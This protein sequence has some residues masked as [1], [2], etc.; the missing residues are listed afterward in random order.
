MNKLNNDELAFD[1]V[2]KLIAD[3]AIT[4]EAKTL[5]MTMQPKTSL[6]A[7]RMLLNETEEML[8]VLKKGLHVPF[9]SSDSIK[10]LL[11]KVDKGLILDALELEK[12]ADFIR[13]NRLLKRFLSK[14]DNNP[15]LNSYANELTILDSVEEDIY[16]QIEHG[17]VSSYAD[18]DLAR[19]RIQVNKINEDIKS[20]LQHF[21][22][23]KKYSSILQEKLI[24]E[25]DGHYTL[26]IK[27]S[28]HKSFPG[29]VIDSSN[30]GS[31]V[32]ME[33]NKAANLIEQKYQLKAQ[34]STIEL[35]ILGILTASVYD[36]LAVINKNIEIITDIDVILAKAKYAL[37]TN[38]VRA[39][40]NAENRLILK[41]MKH[42]LLTNPVP[43]SITIDDPKRGLI[44]T[45]PNAGGKTITL[46]TIAL[47]VLMTE[48]GSFLPAEKAD[49]PVCDRIFSLIGDQQD[50]DNSL[51]TFSGEMVKIS[52]IV[53]HVQK[54]SLVVLDELGSGT[55][56]NE[57]AALAISVL[58]EL[59]LR[60]CI[61]IA[62][63]HYS[64]IKDFSVKSPAFM[65]A[66]MDFDLKKLQP[67]YRLIMNQTGESRAFWI[68]KK[69]GMSDRIL[70]RAKTILQTDKF[71]LEVSSVSFKKAQNKKEKQF[72]FHKGDIVFAGNI[73]KEAIFYQNSNS[74]DKIIVFVDQDFIEVPI[75]RVKLLRKAED[76]YPAG[77]NLDLLFIKDWQRYKLNK[78]LNRGSKKA[79]KKVNKNYY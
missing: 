53:D 12:I 27:S 25:K 72:D 74:Q 37:A 20:N 33:P 57:G 70:D 59:Q 47:S 61:V 38:S 16:N 55:D 24:I 62:T 2:R 8:N 78:D 51:S 52:K 11:Q 58:Q 4:P 46:K 71:P 77:Y 13:V 3:Y 21:L 42:P 75:K 43:L 15:I 54:H 23:S 79:W 10:L 18:K 30:H 66:S 1:R 63:T 65:T 31:T 19:L 40:I 60:G 14:Q 44:I 67:T 49:I 17:E 35:Q 6:N 28:Y 48:L 39:D 73:N 50:I 26:P 68:A 41:G 29:H 34:I 9:V 22:Q 76:L 64:T 36:K 45:G 56:P 7:V 69:S 5:I 32:F